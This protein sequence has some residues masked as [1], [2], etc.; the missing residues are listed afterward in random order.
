MRDDWFENDEGDP[1]I[2]SLTKEDFEPDHKMFVKFMPNRP[3]IDPTDGWWTWRCRGRKYY[4]IGAGM[5]G[6]A[7]HTWQEAMDGAWEHYKQFHPEAYAWQI[8]HGSER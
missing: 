3:G 5:N 8:A 4:I 6:P 2:N 1:F 7:Y